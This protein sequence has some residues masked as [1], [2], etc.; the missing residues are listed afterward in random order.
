M[1]GR[2]PS[3][4]AAGSCRLLYRSAG[5]CASFFFSRGPAACS[6]QPRPAPCRSGDMGVSYKKRL[7]GVLQDCLFFL[8]NTVAFYIELC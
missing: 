6:G 2:R 7:S 5:L 4:E 8:M 3:V 1:K